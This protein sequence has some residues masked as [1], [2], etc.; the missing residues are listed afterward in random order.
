MAGMSANAGDLWGGLAAMLVALPSAIAFGV[1]V[2]AAIDPAYASQG[3]L[4]GMLG[5]AALGLVAP[6]VGRTPALVTA[7]C[8][9]AAAIL[10]A[11]LGVSI[12]RVHD[13]AETRD[14]LNVATALWPGWA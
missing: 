4:Y 5:A 8:A 2:Y 7:P 3:A 9:P 1:L 14:V 11:Q 6:L 12:V 10:A 13:V